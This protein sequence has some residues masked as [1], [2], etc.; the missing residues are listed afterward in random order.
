MWCL[1]AV[2]ILFFYFQSPTFEVILESKIK[3]TNEMDTWLA[4]SLL[5]LVIFPFREP[6]ALAQ[7]LLFSSVPIGLLAAFKFLVAASL[8]R[9]AQVTD[10]ALTRSPITLL[11]AAFFTFLQ[12]AGSIASIVAL[13]L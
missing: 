5:G 12:L 11:L 3:S 1:T 8:V 13:F 7:A 4:D 2:I 6:E 10:S 9:S